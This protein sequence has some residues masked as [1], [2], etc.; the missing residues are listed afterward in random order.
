M[1]LAVSHSRGFSLTELAIVLL[2]V[3][4]LTTGLMVPLSA[5]VDQRRTRET[6]QMLEQAK[7]A[8]LGYAAAH[9]RLPCPATAAS[10]G[11]ESFAA[12]GT[13]GNGKCAAF[14]SGFLPNADL[15]LSPT[16][17]LGFFIDA[18]GGDTANRIRYAVAN[19]TVNGINNPFTSTGGMK[20]TAA[21]IDDATGL[22]TSG[23]TYLFVC[24][25]GSGITTADCGTA[26]ALTT[27]AP[28]LIYSVG[29][30]AAT[31]GASTDESANP[32]PNGGSSDDV[33]VSHTR[34]DAPGNEFDDQLVWIS[35]NTLIARMLAAGQ[36][37]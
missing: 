15:G 9:G 24:A 2:I 30:N 21:G 10:L 23:K 29:K 7:E 14:F 11:Q 20:A 6:Q 12:G 22:T 37:P 33:F 13:A 16:D 5:Q 31:G 36:L 18:W 35:L 32:N 4:L 3:L 8:L 27:K 34:I 28:A 26:T 1:P 19:N 17:S 25:S